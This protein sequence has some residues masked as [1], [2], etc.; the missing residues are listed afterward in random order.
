MHAFQALP[1]LEPDDSISIHGAVVINTLTSRRAKRAGDELLNLPPCLNGRFLRV[2]LIIHLPFRPDD[3]M[4]DIL[5]NMIRPVVVEDLEVRR[6]AEVFFFRRSN[7]L[8]VQTL[9]LDECQN[10][11]V[12]LLQVVDVF[13]V[14]TQRER[15]AFE[16]V[17][18]SGL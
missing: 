4:R 7:I 8:P 12:C 14:C 16:V 15:V 18:A 2:R 9:V 3:E 10:R 11:A 13:Q 5:I 17:D 1:V 6:V